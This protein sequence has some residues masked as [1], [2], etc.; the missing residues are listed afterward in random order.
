MLCLLFSVHVYSSELGNYFWV[1][2]VLLLYVRSGCD[3]PGSI[4]SFDMLYFLVLFD[5]LSA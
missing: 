5:F 4:L 1:P 3:T 2:V